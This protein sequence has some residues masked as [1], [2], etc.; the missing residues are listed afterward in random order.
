MPTYEYRCVK[1]GYDFE[2]VQKFTDDPLT[3]CPRCGAELH[4]VFSSV[5]I[6][7]KGPGFYSTDA[8]RHG[9]AKSSEAVLPAA[10]GDTPKTV[11]ATTDSRAAEPV[12]ASAAPKPAAVAAAAD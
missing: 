4:K 1:C 9:R 12:G 5:G 10:V 7:F 8:T 2:V 3:V 11:D 6:V